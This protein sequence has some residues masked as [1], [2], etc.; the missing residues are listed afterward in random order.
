MNE[1]R[2]RRRASRQVLL[3]SLWLALLL[4]AM[5]LWTGWATQSLS[6]VAAA[7]HTLLTCFS[8]VLSLIA[9]SYPAI[10]GREIWGHGRLEAGM[11]LLLVAFMGFAGFSVIALAV[12]QLDAIAARQPPPMTSQITL[13]LVQILAV[14]TAIGFCVAGFQRY[15]AGVLESGLLRFNSTYQFQDVWLMVLLLGGLLGE[16]QGYLWLDP[17]MALLLI[18]VTT[19]NCWRMFNR[20]LPSLMRQ[21]AIAPEAVAQTV[22][23]VEGI[24]HCYGI[25]SRGIVGRQVLIELHLILHPE[26]ASLARSIA[27]RVERAIR[28]RYGPAWVIVHIDSD[29]HAAR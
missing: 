5:K 27:D 23:Q 24:T 9:L 7:L 14:V 22:H 16:R 4:L 6:L 8:I 12:Q 3:A 13:P 28:D 19:V 15:Q 17:V 2:R 26:C 10:N 25:Q 29:S 21:M 11:S 20:Q 18:L 1:A